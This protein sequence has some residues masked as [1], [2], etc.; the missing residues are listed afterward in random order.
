MS[1]GSADATVMFQ[2]RRHKHDATRK[3]AVAT[4]LVGLAVLAFLA[5][6]EAWSVPLIGDSHRW[7]LASPW[8]SIPKT[9]DVPGARL[10]YATRRSCS[11]LGPDRGHQNRLNRVEAVLGLVEHDAG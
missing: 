10:D 11:A 1:T 8:Q 3:D 7:G 6:H 2:D 5:T 9:C 4:S